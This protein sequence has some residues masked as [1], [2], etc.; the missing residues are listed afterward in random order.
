MPRRPYRTLDELDVEE[1]GVFEYLDDETARFVPAP[2]P[3]VARPPLDARLDQRLRVE[4]P[5]L[6]GWIFLSCFF[7]DPWTWM[8][9]GAGLI[10]LNTWLRPAYEQRKLGWLFKIYAGA[11]VGQLVAGLGLLVDLGP[12]R[13]LLGIYLVGLVIVWII[14]E[15]RYQAR[16]PSEPQ[17]DIYDQV[18]YR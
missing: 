2:A 10:A 5:M 13:A 3:P 15:L 8:L 7:R 12:I 9:W 1:L 6:W 16:I 4:L 14:Q 18:Y 17:H 11:G